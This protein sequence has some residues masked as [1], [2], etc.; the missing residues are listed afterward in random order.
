[1]HE[2]PATSRLGPSKFPGPLAAAPTMSDIA[3]MTDLAGKLLADP[4]TG[5][6]LVLLATAAVIDYR[7]MR[8]P[9]W[10]T[11]AGALSAFLLH[12]WNGPVAGGLLHAAG[13]LLTGL[14]LLLPLWLLR[15][16]GAG[17]VKLMAMVGA[18]LGA[19]PVVAAALFSF[20]AGGVLALLN[21]AAT[22]SWARV[23]GNLRFIAW[24]VLV[25]SPGGLRAGIRASTTTTVGKLP[26]GI[27]ICAGTLAYLV[28]RQLG[29]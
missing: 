23:G 27:G 14:V 29:F 25:P 1:M 19:G 21:I 18:F 24:S 4:A 11:A 12:A 9:N 22:R 28:M 5:A 16:L 26:Y 8:I 7:T 2:P 17:D 10:L 15:V 6:L 3:F 20:I 13:G